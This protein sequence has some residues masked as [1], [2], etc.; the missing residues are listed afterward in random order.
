MYYTLIKWYLNSLF[1]VLLMPLLA[2]ELSAQIIQPDRFEIVGEYDNIDV[3]PAGENG[4][5]LVSSNREPGESEVEWQ[6][7]KLDT[8]FFGDWDRTYSVPKNQVLLSKYFDNGKLYFLFSKNDPKDR[9]LELISFDVRDGSAKS[10]V[11]RNYIPFSLFDFKVTD[12]A[13]IIGGYFN[14]RPLVILYNFANQIPV[15][16]PGLFIENADFAQIKVNNRSTFDIL[17][18]GKTIDKKATIFIYTY[19]TNGELL[20]QTSLDTDK[21]KGLLFGRSESLNPGSQIV[22]GVYGRRNS[23]Y[24]RGVFLANVNEDG[25]QDMNYYNYAELG[26]FFNYMRSG[27]ERRVRNRIERRKIKE[28]KIKFTY[29]LLVHDII[30]NGENYILL[31]EAFYPKYKNIQGNY[32]GIFTP[33]YSINRGLYSSNR[34]FD[35]FQYTH[36]V[37]LGF[38]KQGDLLWDNSFEINDVKSF[39]LEQFVH[40]SVEKDKIALL[41]VFNDKIRSKIIKESEVIE[42]KE[43][44]P[45]RLK[46]DS[47]N[48]VDNSTIIQG[49]NSWYDN[50]FITYG[51]QE[52]KNLTS[53]EVDLKRKVFFINKVIYK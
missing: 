48:L 12:N 52:I 7:I 11:I 51:T 4:L 17:L 19:S 20:R 23:E 14:Y 9:N 25:T 3:I 38:N 46:Y 10:Y 34:V 47:D 22:A 42:D 28:K 36:A 5:F 8:A 30:E 44:T 50:V 29:R 16:L 45:I 31:G 24:S 27:R 15:I 13:A 43:L 39:E 18:T 40:A 49:L 1:V 37:L 26:N 53:G 2:M 41:Y 21:K 33:V 35:G 6:V 32:T